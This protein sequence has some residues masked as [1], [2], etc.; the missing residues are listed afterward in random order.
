MFLVTCSDVRYDFRVNTMFCLSLHTPICF[1][2]DSCFI[3]YI[4]I[5]ISNPIAVTGDVNDG[6]HIVKQELLTLPEHLSS[7]PFVG[8]RVAHSQF[9]VCL[10]VPFLKTIVFFV[11]LR[12]SLWYLQ[13]CIILNLLKVSIQ[14]LYYQSHLQ[15]NPTYGIFSASIKQIVSIK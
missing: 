8:V 12:F 7:L 5:L 9:S 1:V 15:L 10:I 6:Y 13:S 2:V 14:I 3:C 11:P 4:H